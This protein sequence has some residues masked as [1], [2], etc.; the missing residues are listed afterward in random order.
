MVTGLD[1]PRTIRLARECGADQF[2]PKPFTAS[3]FLAM[4]SYCLPRPKPQLANPPPSGK[5]ARQRG[6]RRR[7]LT[8]RQNRLMEYMAQGFP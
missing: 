5:G 7:P 2:L 1:D 8:P 3:Q 4:L 6:L